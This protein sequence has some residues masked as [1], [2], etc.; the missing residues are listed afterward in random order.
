MIS[1]LLRRGLTL[2][3]IL[4][5]LQSRAAE[6]VVP[7]DWKTIDEESLKHFQNILRLDT[8]DPPGGERPAVDYLKSVLEAEGIETQIFSIDSNRPN[9]VARIRGNGTKR[10]LLLMGHTDVVNVDPKKWKHPPFSA[11]RAD[12]YIYGRGTVDD[13]DNVTAALM[14]MLLLKRSQLPLERDVIFLAEAFTRPAMMHTLGKVGYQQSY[15]YFT[16]RNTKHE[17][18]QYLNELAHSTSAFFRPNLWVSTPDILVPYLQFGG[19][20]GHKIRAAIAAMAGS[21]WGMYSGYELVEAT[22]RAGA[23]E[24][25]DSEKYEYKPRDW[26]KAEKTGTSIAP[27]ITQLNAIRKAHP[28]VGQI[29]NLEVHNSTGESI[30]VFTKHLSAEHSPTG[31]ADTIIVI[32]NLDPNN[33]SEA[34]INLDLWKLDLGYERPFKV[35]DLLTGDSRSIS[36][37]SYIRID[38]KTQPVVILRVDR[39]N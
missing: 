3:L 14:T 24:H 9:L 34:D 16:W 31:K 7:A 2:G 27:Y 12:G 25:I 10:P 1:R 22:S 15:S 35:T 6:T 5:T 21:S 39:D 38:P 28:A 26:Q 29:R 23:D 20:A 4:L 18:T 11:T 37:K 30:F 19:V 8:S 13:K 17:L 33:V 32:A 36:A